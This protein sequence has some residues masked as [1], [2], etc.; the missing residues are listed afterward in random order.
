MAEEAGAIA[1]AEAFQDRR[2]AG[3]DLTGADLA[4]KDFTGCWFKGVRLPQTRWRDARLEDCRFEDCDLSRMLPDGLGARGVVFAG[5]KLMG[6][7]WSGLSAYPALSF[8]RCDLR[9]GSFVGLRLRKIA[10]TACN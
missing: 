4:G 8:E 10:F 7:D 5:C 2:C 3:G 9:Y 1:A 6:V